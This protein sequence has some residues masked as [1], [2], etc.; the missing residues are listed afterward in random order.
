MYKALTQH[1]KELFW[2]CKDCRQGAEKLLPTITKI[3]TKVTRLED[4]SARV[5]AEIKS[6]LT[7]TIAAIADLKKE[8]AHIGGR[9]EQCEEKADENK[10]GLDSSIGSKVV[11]METRILNKEG[12]KWSEIVSSEVKSHMTQAATDIVT[13]KTELQNQA[14]AIIEDKQEQ[15]EINKRRCSVIIHG[16]AE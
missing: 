12:P 16:L 4:E 15:D 9:I 11:E 3:H 13:A 2:F 10:R 14:R 7:R 6:E 8:V 5:S 1:A